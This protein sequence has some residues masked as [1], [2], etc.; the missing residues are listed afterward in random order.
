VKHAVL[1]ATLVLLVGAAGCARKAKRTADQV[2]RVN[3]E[4]VLAGEI[5]QVT[6]M[7]REQI[8]ARHPEASLQ[9]G[10]DR[11]RRDAARQLIAN[12]LL[13]TEAQERGLAVPDSLV[14]RAWDDLKQRYGGADRFAQGIAKAGQTEA[15]LRANMREGLMIDTLL[16]GLLAQGDSVPQAQCRAYYE[17][18]K[19]RFTSPGKTGAG[20]PRQLTFDEVKG[21]IL[22]M[23]EMKARAEFVQNHIDSL[24]RVAKVE[25][26]DTAYAPQESIGNGN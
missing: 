1:V 3:G 25:Y 10:T 17:E 19:A 12:R 7:L 5:E 11:F 15:K 9:D 6:Q 21:Q 16:K 20:A 13:L 8:L 14:E 23:L 22:A 4:W 26:L 2:V 18:N 24:V